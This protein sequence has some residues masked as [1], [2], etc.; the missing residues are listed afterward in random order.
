MKYSYRLS[1]LVGTVYKTGNQ[2]FTPDGNCLLS[3]VGNKITVFDLVGCV[4]VRATRARWPGTV[5]GGEPL[6]RRAL[7]LCT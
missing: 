2:L 6:P 3:P 5:V 1:N 4:C 7:G